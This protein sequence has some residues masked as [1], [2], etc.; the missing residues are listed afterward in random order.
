MN[1][2]FTNGLWWI[3]DRANSNQHQLLWAGGGSSVI[4]LPN[5]AKPDDTSYSAPSGNS[6]AWC[7]NA[8]DTWAST[9]AGVTAGTIASSGY[10]NGTAGFSIVN[11]SGT[12]T[13]GSVGHALGID[14]DM[15]IV[16]S[17]N[18]TG[19]V[20]RFLWHSSLSPADQQLYLQTNDAATNTPDLWDTGTFNSNTFSV[21]TNQHTNSSGNNYVAF[22]WGAVSGYS[23]FGSYTGL[24]NA[25]GA[26]VY[27]G[28]RPAY[29]LI[30]LA[31]ASGGSWSLHDSTRDTH[32]PADT[33]IS[34]NSAGAEGANS[35]TQIDLLSNGFKIRGESGTTGQSGAQL[36]YAAFAE[37]PF[38]GEN[39]PPATAR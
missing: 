23:D 28:F 39:A 36:V 10:R 9:D 17:T 18:A 32:N 25:N 34:F 37:S 6:V 11:W 26:F 22:C 8:P 35:F 13:A 7:W 12:G 5:V 2:G 1:T 27:T 4:T 30:K 19:G 21:G 38:G 33:D 14:I 31:G 20:S 3:K 24:G 15:I 16:T 29:V